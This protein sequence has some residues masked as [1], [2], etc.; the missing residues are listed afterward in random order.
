[1][2]QFFVEKAFA[3]KFKIGLIYWPPDVDAVNTIV[4]ATAT[5]SPAGLLLDGDVERSG[6]QVLQ[7]ISGG[8]S[9][10]LYTVQF[11]V[12]TLD[13]SIYASPDHDAICVRIL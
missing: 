8:T 4:S 6:S 11:T 1:M 12:T 3:E 7:M 13:G 2:T 5:V 10:V 9:G